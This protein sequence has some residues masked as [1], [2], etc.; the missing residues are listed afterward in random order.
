MGYSY[1]FFFFEIRL[2]EWQGFVYTYD[3][4]TAKKNQST[5]VSILTNIFYSN[6]APAGVY[7]PIPVPGIK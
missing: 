6:V 1:L 7:F 2:F 5:L 3:K 4:V